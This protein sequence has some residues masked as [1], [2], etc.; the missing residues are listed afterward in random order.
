MFVIVEFQE[1]EEFK[2]FRI[3]GKASTQNIIKFYEDF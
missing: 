1:D 3:E 2:T